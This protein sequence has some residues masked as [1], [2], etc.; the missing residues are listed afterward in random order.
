VITAYD[1]NE[2]NSMKSSIVVNAA[3]V[4]DAIGIKNADSLLGYMY[5]DD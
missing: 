4:A 5:L 1:K 3:K 2:L